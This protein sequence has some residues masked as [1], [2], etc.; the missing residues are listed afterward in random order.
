[1]RKVLNEVR[2]KISEK[3]PTPTP[4]NSNIDTFYIMFF[5]FTHFNAAELEKKTNLIEML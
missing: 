1:M 5:H 3:S 2:N 4:I